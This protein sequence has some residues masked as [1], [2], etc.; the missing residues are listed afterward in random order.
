MKFQ[1]IISHI[2]A[3]IN[4][5]D[6]QR[7]NIA[8]KADFDLKVKNLALENLPKY[9][10]EIRK[11]F[12]ERILEEDK[13][14]K[15]LEQNIRNIA[16]SFVGELIE[17]IKEIIKNINLPEELYEAWLDNEPSP[18]LS[19]VAMNND[20]FESPMAKIAAGIPM[21]TAL[22]SML[23]KEEWKEKQHT[24]E[25]YYKYKGKKN[26]SNFVEHY[27]NKSDTTN[28]KKLPFDEALQLIEKFGLDTA[29]LHLLLSAYA[30]QCENPY[31]VV[32]RLKGTDL[33]KTLGWGTNNEKQ[34]ELLTRLAN[35]AWALNSLLVKSEWSEGRNNK[36]TM[37]YIETSRMW[38]MAVGVYGQKNIYD[39]VDE[40][41]EVILQVRPG[42]WTTGFLN[43]G[44]AASREAFYHF[45]WLSKQIMDIPQYHNELA[46]QIAMR[47]T[48]SAHYRQNFRTVE[49]FLLE[50]KHGSASA[51]DEARKDKVKRHSLKKDWD[52]TLSTLENV[53]FTI[54]YD[55][56]SYPPN[57]RPNNQ[58]N[59]KYYFEKLLA[60]KLK[61]IP[62]SPKPSDLLHQSVTKTTSS[63]TNNSNR[64][65]KSREKQI[66]GSDIRQAREEAGVLATHLAKYFGKSRAWLSQKEKGVRSLS[67]KEAKEIMTAIKVL[68][69]HTQ[70]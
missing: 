34:H 17:D 3:N 51:I 22:H 26:P 25:A 27:I 24:S 57:L 30:C 28:I 60:A 5:S 42:L 40:P 63:I 35:T 6:I 41:N 20:V 43:Q 59:P 38:E 14:D 7:K 2:I 8:N 47:E 1:Q 23:H 11:S 21:K 54:I 19:Q 36:K 48:I 9:Q 10:P 65:K 49:S 18:E 70:R 33:I 61:I 4:F 52:K 66:T 50:N 29:K 39:Q 68:S 44:G 31:G 53:E 37:V 69:K 58:R 32:M 46:I 12:I 64:Q 13:Y 16:N 55:D 67:Q 15:S 45:G 56:K 62:P